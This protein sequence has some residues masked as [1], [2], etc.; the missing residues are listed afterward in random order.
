MNTDNYDWKKAM[1]VEQ[2]AQKYTPYLDKQFNYVN[3][4]NGGIYSGSNTLI[5]FSLETI[6]NSTKWTNT[7]DH[8][9]TI[10]ITMV[11]A[12]KNDNATANPTGALDDAPLS[13]WAL[14]TLKPGLDFIQSADIVIDGKVVAESQG[15]LN[16]LINV[17]LL[18]EMSQNDLKSIGSTINFGEVL[19]NPHSTICSSAPGASANGNGLANNNV[20][21]YTSNIIAGLANDGVQRNGLVNEALNKR[22]LRVID[23]TRD[24]IE[25]VILS[26]DK[27]RE[28]FR[29]YYER[30]TSG[31]YGVIHDVL[32]VR[33]K[34]L[35]DSFNNISLIKRMNGTL[36]LTVNTGSLW[37][38]V[39]GADGAPTYSFSSA[40]SLFNNVCPFTINN[41]TG[42]T[43]AR[44]G[45]PASTAPD[46]RTLA[47]GIFIARPISTNLNGINLATDAISHPM[48]ACRYYYSS[49]VLESEKALEYSR[50]SQS[51]KVVYRNYY[52][53][54]INDVQP[55][56]NYSSLIQGGVRNPYALIVIPFIGSKNS[57]GSSGYAWQSPF[58]PSLG[59]PCTLENI[60][61]SIGGT[62]LLNTPVNY[63]FESF[64]NFNSCE[65]LSSSDF[66]VSCG[67]ISR[68]F[69]ENNKIYYF[70]F[71]NTISDAM[72]PRSIV[73]SFKNTSLVPVDCL[74]YTLYL[75]SIE[76][77]VDTGQINASKS[78]V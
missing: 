65:S 54:A 55:N 57:I 53:N 77:N 71:S 32:I 45:L 24:N 25:G 47:A 22:A 62:Q 64:L 50:M 60:Q 26:K 30:T 17:R 38:T 15:F 7:C 31:K 44:G 20:F 4:I 51:K 2:D 12:T 42:L 28:D 6:Y 37:L 34:D 58:D 63:T 36:R 14:Q 10:P 68:E 61:I 21:G 74:V 59:S 8:F 23:T 3:D 73:L 69:Y 9:L 70:N 1:N 16:K 43:D 66:G 76:V 52:F 48:T 75:D 56:T 78:N 18:S 33:M 19:D 67:L 5:Q 29:P 11:H 49:I 13:G 39:N 27:I 35:F 41:F 72:T 40:N 46:T